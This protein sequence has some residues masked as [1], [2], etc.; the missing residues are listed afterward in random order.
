MN[1]KQDKVVSALGGIKIL[2]EYAL[3]SQDIARQ[4]EAQ[5]TPA[6]RLVL[7]SNVAEQNGHVTANGVQDPNAMLKARIQVF[8]AAHINAVQMMVQQALQLGQAIGL[9]QTE[10]PPGAADDASLGA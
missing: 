9:V 4:L 5:L 3:M 10:R 6:S 8:G 7:A 1:E 2:A